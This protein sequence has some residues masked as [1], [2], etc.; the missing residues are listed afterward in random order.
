MVMVIK[1]FKTE[2]AENVAGIEETH[3]IQAFGNLV[4]KNLMSGA[5][6]ET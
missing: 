5:N 1:S 2:W 3:N 4:G 6:W